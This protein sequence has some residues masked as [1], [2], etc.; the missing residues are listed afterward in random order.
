MSAIR[1]LVELLSHRVVASTF[2]A[3]A[4]LVASLSQVAC[5]GK[6]YGPDEGAHAAGSGGAGA[7]TGGTAGQGG[8][9][10]DRQPFELDDLFP[11]FNAEAEIRFPAPERDEILHLE[12]VGVPARASTSTHNLIDMSWASSVDFTAKALTPTRLLVSVGQMQ[13]TPDY[14]E[15]RDSDTPWPTTAV[16]VGG[17]EWQ[18]FSVPISAM[19]PP[20]VPVDSSPSFF[21]A[22][23]VEQPEPVEVWID[24]VR[25]SAPP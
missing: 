10:D 1:W 15:A 11:W 25:F 13:R 4:V 19:Q 22:F 9:A 3:G 6:S 21:L 7:V 18:A 12:A 14:F 20:D 24:A 2:A 5:G 23:S 8:V 16:D 17:G